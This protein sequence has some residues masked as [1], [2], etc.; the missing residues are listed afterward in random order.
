[1]KFLLSEA[2]QCIIFG[3]LLLLVIG[4]FNDILKVITGG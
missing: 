4:G 2:G 3:I 1:M